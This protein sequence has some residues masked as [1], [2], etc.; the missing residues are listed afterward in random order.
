MTKSHSSD[1][2]KCSWFSHDQKLVDKFRVDKT[3]VGKMS[4]DKMLRWLKVAAPVN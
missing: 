1:Y 4:L 2:L 3:F